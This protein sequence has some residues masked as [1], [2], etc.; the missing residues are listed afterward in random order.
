M[1]HTYSSTFKQATQLKNQEQ[2]IYLISGGPVKEKSNYQHNYMYFATSFVFCIAS[3]IQL[4]MHH[5]EL[6]RWNTSIYPFDI[7]PRSHIILVSF[8]APNPEK[9][10]FNC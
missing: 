10:S 1:F 3:A 5:V 4:F 8:T 2:V 7:P 6:N 9:K